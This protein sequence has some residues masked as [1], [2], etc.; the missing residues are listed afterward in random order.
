MEMK[1]VIKVDKETE[2]VIREFVR[3]CYDHD[4]AEACDIGTLASSI[5]DKYPETEA[6]GKLI[7]VI[8]E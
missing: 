2:K 1:M 5:E 3:F 8:Y 6:N 7:D 4:I